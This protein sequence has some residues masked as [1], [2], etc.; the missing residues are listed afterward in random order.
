MNAN[1]ETL[2]IVVDAIVW[3]VG[4]L[5]FGGLGRFIATRHYADRRAHR[6]DNKRTGLE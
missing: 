5:V 2:R 4:I 6:D 1:I 3:I